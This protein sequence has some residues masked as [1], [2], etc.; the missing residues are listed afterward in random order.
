MTDLQKATH[1]VKQID[2]ILS[3]DER[4]ALKQWKSGI[5]TLKGI[6]NSIEDR[7]FVTENQ[8]QAIQ[9]IKWGKNG[10]D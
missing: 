3:K 4:F 2:R 7:G 5:A 10:H 1:W 8:I 6:K 9:N